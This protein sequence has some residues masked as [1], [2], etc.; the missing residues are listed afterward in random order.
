MNKKESL[1][2]TVIDE[3]VV[4]EVKNRYFLRNTITAFLILLAFYIA[5]NA[6]KILNGKNG[7]AKQELVEIEEKNNKEIKIKEKK[8]QK[9]PQERKELEIKKIAEILIR[10]VVATFEQRG[11]VLE[12]EDAALERLA[13]EGYD[14]IYGA[15]SLRRAI[16]N[17]V[18]NNL[19][20]LIL[21][22][23][24]RRGDTVHMKGDGTFKLEKRQ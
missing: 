16:Q 19:A 10:E 8:N 17:E 15:R 22:E 3:E 24:P 6:L 20:K 9:K 21:E 1:E 4:E 13:D 23:Q 11:V 12:I 14:P 2:K 18:K 7:K 5:V